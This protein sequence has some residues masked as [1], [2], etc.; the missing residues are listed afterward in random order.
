MHAALQAFS[1]SN[2]FGNAGDDVGAKRCAYPKIEDCDIDPR[3]KVWV[4]RVAIATGR[5]YEYATPVGGWVEERCVAGRG[6]VVEGK[7]L[8][9]RFENCRHV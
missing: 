8:S 4:R 7:L 5:N 1:R 6:L 9:R 2:R 3:G